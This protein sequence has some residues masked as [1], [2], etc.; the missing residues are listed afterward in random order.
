MLIVLNFSDQVI[1]LPNRVKTKISQR[2]IGNYSTPGSVDKVRGW[3]AIVYGC[4]I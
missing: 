2:L 1:N 4:I 3:E